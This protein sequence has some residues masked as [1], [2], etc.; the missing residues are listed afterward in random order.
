MLGSFEAWLLLRGMRTLHLRVERCC[1]TAQAIA[2]HFVDHHRRIVASLYP[3][4][5]NHP[6]H[7]VAARQML[8]ALAGCSAFALPAARAPRS[9]RPR[10]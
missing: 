5:P 10:G 2:E 3:G 6:G 4:L 8:A 9:Q 7:V 1:R